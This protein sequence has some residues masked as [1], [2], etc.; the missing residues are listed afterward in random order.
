VCS[1]QIRCLNFCKDCFGVD[2]ETNTPDACAPQ[3]HTPMINSVPLRPVAALAL[4]VA[5]VSLQA[6]QW[7]SASR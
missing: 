6:G 3:T 1:L 5:L 7:A 4:D 2:T